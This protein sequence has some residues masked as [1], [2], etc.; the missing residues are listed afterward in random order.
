MP[1][2]PPFDD[3]LVTGGA[4]GD[5]V[6]Q[7]R[8]HEL[9]LAVALAEHPLP[10]AAAIA[11][12]R[13]RGPGRFDE[14][15]QQV[16][17]LDQSAHR[18]AGR[19][20]PA[21]RRLEHHRHVDQLVVE[22]GAV[23]HAA[24]LEELLAMIGGDHDQRVVPQPA[25]AQAIE[26]L[27]DL[28]VER[29]QLLVVL[30]AH[31]VDLFGGERHRAGSDVLAQASP[32][33]AQRA[34]LITG[35]EDA[36][37]RRRRAIR[38]VQLEVV[39]VGEERPLGL[40][41]EPGQQLLVDVRGLRRLVVVDVEAL[42]EPELGSELVL[43]R[44]QRGG[45]AESA[46]RL[47]DG[48]G[49]RRQAAAHDLVTLLQESAEA[50]LGRVEAG[51]QGGDRGPG[52]ARLGERSREA[53]AGGGERL[54]PRRHRAAVRRLGADA[55]GAQAVD[56]QQEDVGR[57]RRLL[58]RG[59][60]PR[61]SP[62][63]PRRRTTRRERLGGRSRRPA[64]AGIRRRTRKLYCAYRAFSRPCYGIHSTSRLANCHP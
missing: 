46:Q 35:G 14:R 18:G 40:G 47:G 61:R 1:G 4:D 27:T 9:A 19:R 60:A 3:E 55:V 56:H 54:E 42:I 36:A 52:P 24:V 5:G 39:Q 22:A 63:S 10:Q 15:R 50:V 20:T 2:P 41:V 59:E 28:A 6:A 13:G 23:R 34:T 43:L 45:V 17:V 32:V 38:P 58:R 29:E 49:R 62:G 57:G 48:D 31:G 26:Q 64:D 37:R 16:A 21:R 33:G 30:P 7:L 11:G 53:G 8:Y 25:L 12:R 51:E 44:E